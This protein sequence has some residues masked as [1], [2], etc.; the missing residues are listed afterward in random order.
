MELYPILIEALQ[1]IWQLTKIIILVVLPLMVLIEF[2]NEANFFQKIA[3]AGEGVL[4]KFSLSKASTFPLLVGL[5]LGFN[6]GAGI[7]I[8]LSRDGSIDKRELKLVC[9][10]L[11]LCHAIVEDNIIFILIGANWAW[12]FLGR[13]A[14]GLIGLYIFSRL[15]KV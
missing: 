4:K 6:F 15:I 10:F 12:L 3:G 7:L 14:L 1:G 5:F 9:V 2:A 13:F 11:S 8:Q